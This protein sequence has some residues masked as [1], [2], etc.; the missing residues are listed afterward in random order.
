[1]ESSIPTVE[2]YNIKNEKKKTLF[3]SKFSVGVLWDTS[4][5]RIDT[6]ERI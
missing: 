2:K 3:L 6:E 4:Y 5:D 1:M